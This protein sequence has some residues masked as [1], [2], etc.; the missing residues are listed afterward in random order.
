MAFLTQQGIAAVAGA[1][2]L[3]FEV[4]GKMHDEPVFRIQPA[5]R[6]QPPDESSFALDPAQCC[7]SHA[8]H[9]M[10]I[11]DDIGTVG[12]FHAAAR[13]GRIDGAH[14][15]GND[16]QRAALHASAEFPFHQCTR[17]RRV[18]PVVVRAG[19][20]LPRGAHKGQVF[21][22]GYIRRVGTMKVTARMSFLVEFDEA[23]RL[24]LPV[25]QFAILLFGAIAPV[26]LVGQ[27]QCGNPFDPGL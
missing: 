3:N 22:A 1:E 17:L 16:I 11:D 26:H 13:K 14:A 6:M 20:L 10:H 19:V 4:F 9:E 15:I 7:I 27:G 18:H 12:N 5:N 24:Q 2:T 25:D 8:R 21:H 23:A